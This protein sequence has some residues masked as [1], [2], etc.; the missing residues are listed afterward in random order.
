MTEEEAKG[1]ILRYRNR[2]RDANGEGVVYAIDGVDRRFTGYALINQELIL[3]FAPTIEE[4]ERGN[5]TSI[6]VTWT[7]FLGIIGGPIIP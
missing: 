3:Y 4:I 2:L 7:R 1:N 5:T 6:R